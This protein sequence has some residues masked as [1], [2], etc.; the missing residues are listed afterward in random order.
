MLPDIYANAGG[1]IVSYFEW[2]Q[3]IEYTMA[4]FAISFHIIFLLEPAVSLCFF[5][6]AEHS[7][8]HVG[9]RKGEHGAP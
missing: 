9:R 8:I 3:V 5:D 1:V 7:R 4:A 6:G 2:V